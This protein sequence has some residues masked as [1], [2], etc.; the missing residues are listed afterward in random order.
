MFFVGYGIHQIPFNFF[1]KRMLSDLT[2][3]FNANR[4]AIMNTVIG[5][6]KKFHG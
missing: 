4:A 1:D 2:F 5:V 6:H 3:G